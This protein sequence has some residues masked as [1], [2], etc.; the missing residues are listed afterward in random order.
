[1]ATCF[2]IQP[3]DSGKFDKRFS[4]IYKPAIEAAG[5]EA[6]RVDQD[7]GVLVPIESIE[8]GIKQAAI[9]LADITA[10]NPNVWY[11]LGYAFASERPVVMVCSEERTGK[12]YP[13][14]IQHRSIIPYS[15]DA[16]S[17]FDRLRENL[18]AK[19]NA[20]IAQDAVI[21]RIAESDVV[22]PVHGLSQAEVLA[23]AIIAGEAWL[24]DSAAQ[25]TTI[26]R[27][28]ER[29]GMTNM[30]LNL[31]V[32]RLLQ[33]KF[34]REQEIWNEHDAEGYSGLAVADQGWDWIIANESQFT[35]FRP[36]K[37]KDDIP[38]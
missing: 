22:A 2:V 8:K 18:T 16:P 34:L 21:E 6:Y 15:A 3:F 36:D 28:A 30:G 9:C 32:R 5:L 37:K 4:D 19:I 17:D 31:A 20:I 25:V 1:L 7:A 27:S 23:L 29:A 26:K 13:F 14:D 33:K 35:L 10:D 24:P 11:E 12:K 38:F